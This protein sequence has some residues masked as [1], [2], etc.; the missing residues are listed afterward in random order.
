MYHNRLQKQIDKLQ[1]PPLVEPHR[2]PVLLSDSKG[3]N[4]KNQ[5][6]I[7]PETFIKFWCEAGATAENRLLFLQQNLSDKLKSFSCG[8]ITLYVW[9]GTCDLSSKRDSFIY[10]KATDNS[11]V[12]NLITVLKSIY[13]FVSQFDQVKLVFLHLPVYSISTYNLAHGFTGDISDFKNQDTI[14]KNQISIVNQYIDD[15]NRILHAYSPKF[16]QDLQKSKCRRQNG[17]STTV[18]STNFTL[19]TDG[20]HPD[21]LLAKLWLI[22]ITRLIQ[23]DCY[24]W[25]RAN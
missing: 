20:L 24:D 5:V 12:N 21:K 11:A 16:S 19:Y 3:F 17:R 8:Q 7:N 25:N 6:R 14:L 1:L 2:T 22:R 15:T 23:Q 18:Y 9:V 10:L 4:L 13:H